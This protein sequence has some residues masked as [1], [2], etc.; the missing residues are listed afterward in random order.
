MSLEGRLNVIRRYPKVP[1]GTRRHPKAPEGTRRHPNA[2]E[3]PLVT[4]QPL[5][6]LSSRRHPRYPRYPR[7][8]EVPEM[9]ATRDIL[10]A[11]R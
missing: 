3:V 8:L 2:P 11:K 10:F 6:N 1:E 4:A 7:N 9:P 5:E